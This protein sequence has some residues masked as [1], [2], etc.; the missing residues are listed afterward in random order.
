MR[1][2]SAFIASNR[3]LR[4]I[5]L[6]AGFLAVLLWQAAVIAVS[7]LSRFVETV[8]TFVRRA[9]CAGLV[10]VPFSA[11]W[12]NSSLNPDLPDGKPVS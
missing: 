4:G 8:Q 1:N 7:P 3:L 9:L 10:Y 2:P 5:S 6:C 12:S 11:I